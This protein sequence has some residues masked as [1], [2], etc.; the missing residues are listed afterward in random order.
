[1][2]ATTR[3]ILL[4]LAA[5][6][7]PLLAADRTETF[8]ASTGSAPKHWTAGVTGKGEARWTVEK[9]EGAPSGANVLK[10]SGVADYA[11]IMKDEPLVKNGFVEVKGKAVSGRKDQAIGVIFRAEDADNYY[12]C[13]ANAL[14]DNVVLYKTVGGK[15]S[16]LDIVGR[17]SGYGVKVKV[18]PQ[19]WHTLRVE[20]SGDLFKVLFNGKEL[21]QV[22]DDTFKEAG[23][24]GLWTKAD[25]VI[26]FDDFNCGDR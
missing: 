20:F 9:V 19:K 21:F 8:D 10:Q 5:L 18:E 4:T 2:K 15:R 6:A 13:R 23:K 12:V 26:L 16:S 1:M 14:E 22:K 25:S 24:T 11:V 3:S 7:S 17:K